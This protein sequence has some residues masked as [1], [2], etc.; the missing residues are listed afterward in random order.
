MK[1]ESLE[2]CLI[3]MSLSKHAQGFDGEYELVVRVRD[4]TRIALVSEILF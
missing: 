4:H 2:D 1:S 3:P